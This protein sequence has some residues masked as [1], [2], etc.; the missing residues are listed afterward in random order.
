MIIAVSL[1]RHSSCYGKQYHDGIRK[2]KHCAWGDKDGANF[3]QSND[4]W[5]FKIMLARIKMCVTEIKNEHESL[6]N[7]AMLILKQISAIW[8]KK[9]MLQLNKLLNN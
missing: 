1:W 6:T 5:H 9:I 8:N 7:M 4:V 3:D 2:G